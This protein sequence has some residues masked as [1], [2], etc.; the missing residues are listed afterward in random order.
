MSCD[1]RNVYVDNSLAV[2]VPSSVVETLQIKT[3]LEWTDEL[4][5]RIAEHH[6]HTK[7]RRLSIDLISRRLWGTNELKTRLI[8]RGISQPIATETVN[9][10]VED[11]WLDDTKYAKAL[12][13]E[14]LRKEPAGRKWIHHK[15]LQKEI[16][17]E[18]ATEVVETELVDICELEMATELA[19]I[20]ISKST[21][22]D[23]STLRRK[24]MLALTRK[25]FSFEVA[26]EAFQLAQ[27]SNT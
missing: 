6:E 14:W 9:Q 20:R 18:I 27:K 10:L 22:V 2:T 25:G 12:I 5:D 15:L 1:L 11:D 8:K 4:A 23:V 17:S 21:S 19:K 3:D 26:S 24:I 7:A 13:K 16:P